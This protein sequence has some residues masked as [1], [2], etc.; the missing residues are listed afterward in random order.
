MGAYLE[1]LVWQAE[2]CGEKWS[3]GHRV[4]FISLEGASEEFVGKGSAME[5]LTWCQETY[6]YYVFSDQELAF[7]SP[8]NHHASLWLSYSY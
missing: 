1:S 3:T 6:F 4:R 5:G 2:L 8:D 7:F